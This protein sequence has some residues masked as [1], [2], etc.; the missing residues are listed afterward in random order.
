[1]QPKNRA[2]KDEVLKLQN[3]L[4]Q[5]ITQLSIFIPYIVYGYKL[6]ERVLIKIP[7][8]EEQCY[9]KPFDSNS[10]F[11]NF[12]S[13]SHRSKINVVSTILISKLLFDASTGALQNKYL[14][15]KLTRC[16]PRHE[17]FFNDK[18]YIYP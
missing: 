14:F 13:I 8:G 6:Y 7:K 16:L 17:T 2:S 1:M 10:R 12:S 4:L 11:R 5:S 18:R 3:N 15:V 9:L